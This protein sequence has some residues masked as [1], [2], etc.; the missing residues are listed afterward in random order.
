MPNTILKIKG[1]N[2]SFGALKAVNNVSF[3]IEKGNV[4]GILGPNGSGKSTTA[5]HVT[6]G[7]LGQGRSVA[8]I[9]LDYRQGTLSRYIANR[10]KFC[11]VSSSKILM[12]KHYRFGGEITMD[13]L[14]SEIE[15]LQLMQ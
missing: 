7:C 12:P 8:S 9:D 5:M 1:L 11:S 15:K 4:Y 3:S 14:D 13:K 6:I 10:Q 2:K